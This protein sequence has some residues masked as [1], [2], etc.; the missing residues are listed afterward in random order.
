VTTATAIF[1]SLLTA[2]CDIRRQSAGFVDLETG[3]P[4]ESWATVATGIKCRLVRRQ[5]GEHMG[6]RRTAVVRDQVCM[7][8]IST[9]VRE[10][11]VIVSG[12]ITFDVKLVADAA[13][14]GH[15]L[16]ATVERRN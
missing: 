7:L 12:G 16:E 2:T 14:E 15:H 13:G 9:D 8:P 5:G 10:G 3:L 6:E 1:E 4:A 11:D